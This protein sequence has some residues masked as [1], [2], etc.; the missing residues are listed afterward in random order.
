MD[1]SNNF[2]CSIP[3]FFSQQHQHDAIGFLVSQLLSCVVERAATELQGS[4][5]QHCFAQLHAVVT[6]L[7]SLLNWLASWQ[8]H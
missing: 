7:L 5:H 6:V 3:G 8:Q 1:D 4:L 2:A